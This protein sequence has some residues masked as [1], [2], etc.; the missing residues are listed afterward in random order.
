MLSTFWITIAWD[1]KITYEDFFFLYLVFFL[2]QLLEN[3]SLPVRFMKLFPFAVSHH[4]QPEHPQLRYRIA[5]LACTL[6][7]NPV[8]GK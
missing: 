2:F 7:C 6:K 1:H 4:L 8:S 5:G 3:R